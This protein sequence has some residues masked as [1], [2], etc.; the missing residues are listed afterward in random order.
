MNAR[1]LQ[2][3]VLPALLAGTR[4]E[5]L[6]EIAGLRADAPLDALSLAGQA[7]R[8]EMPQG[9]AQFDVE[10]WPL[11]ARR[12]VPENVRAQMLRLLNANRCTSETELAVAFAFA[13]N[14]LR[15][16]PFD[17][18]RLDAFVRRHNRYLGVVAQY[19][20][21]R[22]AKAESRTG[23]FDDDALSVENWAEAPIGARLAYVEQLRKENADR[24]RE[25]L[26]KAWGAES[27]EARVRLIGAVQTGLNEADRGF[28]EAALKD[29]APRV[30]AI[31]HR[32]LARLSGS[33]ANNPALAACL[34]RIQKERA[35]LLKR[36]IALKLEL[37]A[38]VKAQ[39]ADRWIREQFADVTLEE[40]SCTLE[41]PIGELS[42]AAKDDPNLLFALAIVATMD[43]RFDV[44]A[45]IA[46][47]LPDAWGRM[48]VSGLDDL[49][50]TDNEERT[51][52]VEAIVRPRDWMP[53]AAL[54]DWGWLLRRIEGPLPE[55]VTREVLK[56]KW[57]SDQLN[58]EKKPGTEVIQT[59]C[60][61][62][63]AG[64]REKLRE[65][66]DGIDPDRKDMG[67]MLLDTLEKL[68]AVR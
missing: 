39:T 52:W 18:P 57:W 20:A 4:R 42:A 55:S 17:L 21:Q 66:M 63:P 53:E 27:A 9:P 13:R 16:H 29:R 64:M 22:E 59:F 7:L 5:A 37:P 28:L 46:K 19:W 50:V 30:R 24:A 33:A 38:N 8:F 67:I 26:E 11:D 3:R 44:V 62:C 54:G 31:A 40:L 60:A 10:A 6:P 32:L 68:E 58:G 36:R 65:Q 25:I 56:S 51:R 2:V 12:I 47:E 43:R 15:P 14:K 61:L 34:E 49:S 45:V 41:I 35:G 1:D 23:Y 48:S